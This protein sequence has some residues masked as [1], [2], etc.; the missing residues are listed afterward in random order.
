MHILKVIADPL[1]KIRW[2]DAVILLLGAVMINEFYVALAMGSFDPAIFSQH[3]IDYATHNNAPNEWNQ[4]LIWLAKH[5]VHFVPLLCYF[6]AIS[7]VLLML[8]IVRGLVAL[9]VSIFFFI[10]WVTQ[11]AYPGAWIFEFLFPALF[12]LCAALSTLPELI[13]PDNWMQRLLG[14]RFFGKLKFRYRFLIVIISSLALWYVINLSLKPHYLTVAWHSALTFGILFLLLACFDYIRPKE[15][16]KNYKK[17]GLF[18][19][20]EIFPWLDLMTIIVGAMLIIQVYSDIAVHWFTVKGYSHLISTYIEGTNAPEWMK[21]ILEW[22]RQHAATMMPIQFAFESIAA[23]LFV[24]FVLRFPFVLL[25]AIF[26]TIL[27]YTEFGVPARWPAHPNDPH[28]WTWELMFVTC[29]TYFIGLNQFA[30][31]MQAKTWKAR[32]LGNRFFGDLAFR[33]RVVIAMI[34][35]LSLG[36]AGIATHVFGAEYRM[37]SLAAGITFFLLL[38][39]LAVID[40][41]RP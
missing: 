32:L 24:T 36:L 5:S 11:W 2:I 28:T 9:G 6:S 13:H 3:T 7:T 21:Y 23:I 15:H 22:T 25:I 35:G 33:W 31:F 10:L 34:G 26:F 4:G 14:P 20:L 17:I 18:Y 1:G 12:G 19:R 29:V 30:A 41:S 8:L 37:I 27:M 40:Y 16:I 39:I 38:L